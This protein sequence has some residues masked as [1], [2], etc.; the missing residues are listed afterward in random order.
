[1]AADDR[2]ANRSIRPCSITRE[3]EHR[4]I[5]RIANHGMI[6]VKTV[7]VFQ[8]AEVCHVLEFASSVRLAQREGPIN[9]AGEMNDDAGKIVGSLWH[10]KFESLGRPGLRELRRSCYWPGSYRQNYSRLRRRY[11]LQIHNGHC[12]G[13]VLRL[14]RGTRMFPQKYCERDEAD[15]EGRYG[16]PFLRGDFFGRGCGAAIL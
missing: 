16:E 5:A 14:G 3:V 10:V 1:M 4:M 12:R 15:R 11:R 6:C 13:D 9:A 8:L 2:T 7:V